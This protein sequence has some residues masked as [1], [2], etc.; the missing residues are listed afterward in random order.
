[1]LLH[2]S[3]RHL[4]AGVWYHWD[5]LQHQSHACVCRSPLTLVLAVCGIANGDMLARQARRSKR[6]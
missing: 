1:V 2:D 3:A 6:K 4:R 5:G